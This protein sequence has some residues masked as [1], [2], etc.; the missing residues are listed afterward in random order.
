MFVRNRLFATFSIAFLSGCAAVNA[1]EGGPRDEKKPSLVNT[2]PASGT[3]NFTGKVITLE[4]DEDVRP[5]DINKELIITPNTGSTYNITSDRRNLILEFNKPLE[6]NTTY[7]LNFHNGIEDITEGNKA[8]EVNLSFSTGN[9]LD[10]ASV[11]GKVLDYLTQA[12]EPDLTVAL[13]PESDTNNIRDHKPYYFTRSSAD[14]SF[15]MQN[16]KAG[17]YWIF[18]HNDK[19]TNE[20]YDQ[21][22]EK[23]GYL[24]QPISVNPTLDS[25]I[26]KTVRLDTKKPFVLSNEQFS[27]QNTL[28]YSEGIQKIS[29]RTLEKNPSEKKLLIMPDLTG[30]RINVYPENGKLPETLLAL[31]TDSLGNQGVDTVKFALTNKPGI[32]GSLT[33]KVDKVEFQTEANNQLKITFPVPINITG[34]APFSIK[35]DTARTITPSYPTDY[36]LN[37]KKTELILN[38]LPKAIKTATLILDSTQ[39]EAINGKRFRKQSQEFTITRK[40]GAGSVTGTIKTNFKNYV[41]E[42]LDEKNAVIKSETNIKKLNYQNLLPGNYQIRVKI[43]ENNDGKWSLG[44]KKFKTLPEKLYVYPKPISVRANWEIADIDLVF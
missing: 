5:K 12:P 14:G 31:S 22:N 23:I 24:I 34:K 16:I 30:K 3:T 11:S 2:T 44:D 39:I 37:E 40:A 13:Y 6:E 41:V 25:V 21:E 19:N 26:L 35:E 20:T 38:Y 15:R 7:N 1:P 33:Y 10:T 36:S 27:D 17:N 4:F 32:P 28:I 18:A 29:F 9:F 8:P 42:L 43:D